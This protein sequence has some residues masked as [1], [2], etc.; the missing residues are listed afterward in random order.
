M[1]I[2]GLLVQAGK[3]DLPG[4][5]AR[6]KELPELSTYGIHKEQ[7]IVVVAEAPS[8]Q[9]EQVVERIN[10]L[11]GVLTTYTAYLT[12]EDELPGVPD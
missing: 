5:E 3:E 2:A 12:V 8:G 10:R 6:L 11:P 7:Y 9:L 1:A 4:V